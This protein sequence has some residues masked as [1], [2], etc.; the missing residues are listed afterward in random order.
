MANQDIN[1]KISTS[2][3][4]RLETRTRNGDITDAL[5]FRVHDALWMLTRQW[6]LGEFK[7]NDAGTA[8]AVKCKAN[9]DEQSREKRD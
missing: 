8:I 3:T 7:G 9:K 6:Q 5:R 4:T 2:L 1:S